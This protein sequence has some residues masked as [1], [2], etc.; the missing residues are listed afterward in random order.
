MNIDEWATQPKFCEAA[1]S[2]DV[3]LAPAARR[4]LAVEIRGIVENLRLRT[5]MKGALR[6]SQIVERL[7]DIRKSLRHLR[8][9]LAPIGYADRTVSLAPSEDILLDTLLAHTSVSPLFVR[10]LLAA[11]D[12]AA[13]WLAKRGE[14]IRSK[15]RGG[16]R[17]RR[18]AKGALVA[19]AITLYESIPRK[20]RRASRK[21]FI[22][23]VA[24]LA[25]I[26]EVSPETIK[27]LVRRRKGATN[28]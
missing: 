5:A 9:L 12:R 13:G 10:D 2:L 1:S 3:A 24:A 20:G 21:R 19:E 14:D 18:E 27:S 8:A 22:E 26:D 6:E 7:R 28:P 4:D 23:A 17:R 25:H 15:D 11:L 16:N